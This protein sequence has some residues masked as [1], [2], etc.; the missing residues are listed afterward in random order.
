MLYLL[1]IDVGTSVVKSVLFNLRGEEI[2]V[3]RRTPAIIRERQ[4]WSEMSME[5]LWQDVLATLREVA[6]SEALRHGEIAGIGLSGMCCSSWLLDDA[7]RPV[8]NAILWNDGRA[9]SII[10][11][12]QREGVMDE[13]FRIGGNIMFPGYTVAVL[14]W[15]QENE[16]ETLERA[17]WSVFCKDWI[18][19]KL[20]GKIATEHSDAGY[21]PYDLRASAYSDT[22]LRACGIEST[23]RLLPEV[24]DSDEITGELL[25]EVAQVTGL[26]AGIPVVAGLVDVAAS[27]LGAGAYRPGQACTIVGTSFLNNFIYAEP[28]F[29][30][31]GIG[32]QTRAGNGGWV[33]SL[34][35]TAGTMNLEWFLQEFCAAER[36]AAE[37]EGRNIYEWAEA[38][39]A[40][41]PIGCEGVIY[42]PYLNTAG[43]IAPFLNPV[44][45]A[46][47]FGISVEHTRAHL[48]RAVYEG[49]ALAMLDNY[50]RVNLEVDEWYIAGGGKRSPFWTQMFADATGRAILVP[51]GEE[52]GARGVAV[53]AGVASGVY[54]SVEDAMRQVIHVTR[55][56]QP[57]PEAHEKY[58][59]VYQL[60]RRIYEHVMDD[61]WERYH[62]LNE[63]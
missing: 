60:Y 3:S 43:V 12:W 58:L 56:H 26:R 2:V 1:G 63:L 5:A 20:T 19:F 30:P 57:N 7:G 54:S 4:G 24:L 11:D 49:T 37:A 42:H 53:L 14:R 33:R 36:A 55:E 39:A 27:T 8:R 35:N 15:L 47:F 50:M 51:A 40:E 44:A 25:P 48:L 45:R 46:Q 34:V 59:K 32:V 28:S 61:W 10:A 29:E 6:S 16:P 52:L 9:A 17:R 21:T 31:A 18:R 23:R 22:L 62:L 41:I 38:V 13:V